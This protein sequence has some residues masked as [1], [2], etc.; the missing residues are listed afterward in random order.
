MSMS[1]VPDDRHS[2]CLC[3]LDWFRCRYLLH[4]KWNKC[5]CKLYPAHSPDQTHLF[6]KSKIAIVGGSWWIYANVVCMHGGV[7]QQSPGDVL[8]HFRWLLAVF[9]RR[10]CIRCKN[11]KSII[12]VDGEFPMEFVCNMLNGHSLYQQTIAHTH[13]ITEQNAI[14]VSS[15]RTNE[16]KKKKKKKN[17]KPPLD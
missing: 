8:F 7:R 1:C 6:N 17:R 10:P 13:F 4:L 5:E 11:E 12:K 14:A 9:S 2:R 16:R 3:W 15:E